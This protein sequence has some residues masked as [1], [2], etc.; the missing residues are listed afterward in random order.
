MIAA[1]A[2]SG[3]TASRWLWNKWWWWS[4]VD[5]VLARLAPVAW[6]AT[7]RSAR[8]KTK[9]TEMSSKRRCFGHS[10]PLQ[11]LNLS[12]ILSQ[13]GLCC[14]RFHLPYYRYTSDISEN[15]PIIYGLAMSVLA[16]SGFG[17]YCCMVNTCRPLVRNIVRMYAFHASLHHLIR[18]RSLVSRYHYYR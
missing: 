11:R 7:R 16:S 17:I 8:Y 14:F 18:M 9:M 13:T 3:H 4:L 15:W 6:R 12:K 2:S 10:I 1:K 5:E